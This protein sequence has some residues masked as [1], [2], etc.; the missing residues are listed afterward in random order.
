MRVVKAD[1]LHQSATEQ[2]K[3]WRKS[4]AVGNL[5]GAKECRLRV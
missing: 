3:D 2:T 5:D 4:G 1:H